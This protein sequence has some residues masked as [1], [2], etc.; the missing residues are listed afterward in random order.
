MLRLRRT[1]RR[2]VPHQFDFRRREAVN[3]VYQIRQSPFQHTGFCSSFTHRRRL[4]LVPG[5]K[6]LKGS[7]Y[8][9]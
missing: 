7:R 4:L 3:S 9:D 8:V 1:G 2:S 5:P 6:I